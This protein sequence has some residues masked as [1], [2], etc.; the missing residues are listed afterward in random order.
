MG[1]QFEFK[2]EETQTERKREREKKTTKSNFA[3]SCYR[4]KKLKFQEFISRLHL[5][6]L[7][8]ILKLKKKK[9]NTK[10]KCYHILSLNSI[11]SIIEFNRVFLSRCIEFKS[12]LI[13]LS[14]FRLAFSFLQVT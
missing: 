12:L 13:N 9:K 3:C 4:E 6:Y 7:L 14:F 10:F 1:V 11:Q 8:A 2:N 5:N